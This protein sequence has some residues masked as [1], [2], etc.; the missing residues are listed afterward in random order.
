MYPGCL[1]FVNAMAVYIL[2]FI[3]VQI[4]VV[5]EKSFLPLTI[6]FLRTAVPRD[7]FVV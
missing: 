1:F 2:T 3:L 7:C 6:K 5:N 4:A